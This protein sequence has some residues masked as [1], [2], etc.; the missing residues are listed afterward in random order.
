MIRSYFNCF[1]VLTSR[2][3]FK[4]VFACSQYCL[5]KGQFS[6]SFLFSTLGHIP[7]ARRREEVGLLPGGGGWGRGLC[8]TCLT[9]EGPRGTVEAA[10]SGHPSRHPH[11]KIPGFPHRALSWLSS[12]TSP[13]R[14]DSNNEVLSLRPGWV[15]PSSAGD[16]GPFVRCHRAPMLR[17]LKTA[18]RHPAHPAVFA[19]IFPPVLLKCMHQGTCHSI[20]STRTFSRSPSVKS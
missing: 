5:M 17:G 14:Q 1:T 2:S 12:G 10:S 8:S 16:R 4:G 3:K 7:G 18:Q 13:E 6:L 11:F 9:R 15:C 20:P 19:G